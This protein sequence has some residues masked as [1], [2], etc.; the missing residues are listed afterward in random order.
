MNDLDYPTVDFRI[1]TALSAQHSIYWGEREYFITKVD[2]SN[3]GKS[4]TN[5]AGKSSGSTT[6]FENYD[7]QTHQIAMLE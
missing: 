4:F 2:F 3:D 6:G 5:I 7:S 1:D